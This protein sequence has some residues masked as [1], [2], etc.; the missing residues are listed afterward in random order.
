[1]SDGVCS[2]DEAYRMYIDAIRSNF[3]E[4][5]GKGFGLDC[6][7]EIYLVSRKPLRDFVKSLMD[8]KA[9]EST[10]DLIDELSLVANISLVAQVRRHPTSYGMGWAVMRLSNLKYVFPNKKENEKGWHGGHS[11]ARP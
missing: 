5:I 1:M 9:P 8:G 6:D 3:K 10:K 7:Q 2:Y 11:T 4:E